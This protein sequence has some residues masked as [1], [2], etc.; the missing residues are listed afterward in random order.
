[1]PWMIEFPATGVRTLQAWNTRD[2]ACRWASRELGSSQWEAVEM[3]PTDRHSAKS[4][5]LRALN[6]AIANKHPLDCACEVALRYL[7]EHT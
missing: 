2:E 6:V 5:A 4:D 7:I 1:M 3:K